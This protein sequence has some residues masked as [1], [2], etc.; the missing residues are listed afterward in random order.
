[1]IAILTQESNVA[2]PSVHFGGHADVFLIADPDTGKIVRWQCLSAKH[3]YLIGKNRSPKY[4]YNH[5][6]CPYSPIVGVY[7]LDDQEQIKRLV[8]DAISCHEERSRCSCGDMD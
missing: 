4:E 5:P 8:N 6:Y 7:D 3:E 1:M 2:W